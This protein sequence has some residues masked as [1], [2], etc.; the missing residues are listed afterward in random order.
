MKWICQEGTS[1]AVVPAREEATLFN[2]LG[3]ATAKYAQH[4]DKSM[5]IVEHSASRC[6]EC[7]PKSPAVHW[8]G[9]KPENSK[10]AVKR[11]EEV[12]KRQPPTFQIQ[13]LRTSANV[14][15]MKDF[16]VRFVFNSLRLAH[17]AHGQLPKEN[18]AMLVAKASITTMTRTQNSHVNRPALKLKSLAQSLSPLPQ[19]Q[20]DDN[21]D[22]NPFEGTGHKLLNHQKS[23]VA[24]MLKHERNPE[25]FVEREIEEEVVEEIHLRLVGSATRMII[26]RGGV[27]A[28]DIGFGKTVMMLA[29]FK[30]QTE[31]DQHHYELRENKT[32]CRTKALKC[33]M[34]I[35]PRHIVRQWGQ[36]ANK[37]LG[38][39]NGREFVLIEEWSDLQNLKPDD[40]TLLVVSDNIFGEKKYMAALAA[41]VG[42]AVPANGLT[43]KALTEWKGG[44]GYTDWQ[45]SIAKSID[46]RTARKTAVVFEQY[47][48]NRIVWDEVSYENPAVASFVTNCPAVS[49]WLLSGTPPTRD[50]K[51]VCSMATSL[52]LHI[53]RPI[54]LRPGLPRIANGPLLSP[55][56]RLEEFDSYGITKSSEFSLERHR[57]AERF[58]VAFTACNKIDRESHKFQV[59]EQVLVCPPTLAEA[60]TYVRFQA[61]VRIAD[62]DADGLKPAGINRMKQVL[63]YTKE[64]LD[65]EQLAFKALLHAANFP[66]RIQMSFSGRGSTDSETPYHQRVVNEQESLLEEARI[67]VKYVFKKLIWLAPR[68][69]MSIHEGRTAANQQA[70]DKQDYEDITADLSIH[71]DDLNKRRLKL[72]QGRDN[73]A[74]LAKAILPA[75]NN[76]I[77]ACI[78]NKKDLFGLDAIKGAKGSLLPSFSTHD[79]NINLLYKSY[80]SRWDEFY[81][82]AP[83]DAT[84]RF[85][86]TDTGAP[87]NTMK[88]PNDDVVNLLLAFGEYDKAALEVQAQT[89]PGMDNL[90]AALKK[91]IKGSL[92]R[93]DTSLKK[94]KTDYE[95]RHPDEDTKSLNDLK[96]DNL[97]SILRREGLRVDATKSKS[98][99]IDV[100][101]NHKNMSS[102]LGAYA[103]PSLSG[104]HAATGMP[105]LKRTLRIRGATKTQTNDE[106]FTTWSAFMSACRNLYQQL[107]QVRCAKVFRDIESQIAVTCSED[108]CNSTE[109]LELV[110]QCG[111][112]L[113]GAHRED[114]KYC[115]DG[116]NGCVARWDSGVVKLSRFSRVKDRQILDGHLVSSKSNETAKDLSLSSKLIYVI[117]LIRAV[118]ENERVVMFAQHQSI[119]ETAMKALNNEGIK[120]ATTYNNVIGNPVEDFK[121]GKYKVLLMKVNSAEAAGG[122]LVMANHVIFL[123]PVIGNSQHL[124]NSHMNQASG[125]C[126][127][128]GQRAERVH[129]YHCVMEGTIEVEVLELR[130]RQKVQVEPGEALGKLVPQN[131]TGL[132]PVG[133]SL[134]SHEVWK[135]LNEQDLSIAMDFENTRVD[136]SGAYV[137]KDDAENNTE[138]NTNDVATCHTLDQFAD[139]PEDDRAQIRAKYNGLCDKYK[140]P[141][142]KGQVEYDDDGGSESDSD[143]PDDDDESSDGD[144]HMD[145]HPPP[146]GKGHSG[147][148]KHSSK[149]RALDAQITTKAYIDPKAQTTTTT[150]SA[151]NTQP[152]TEPLKKHDGSVNSKGLKRAKTVD[153]EDNDVDQDESPR[154]KRACLRNR[155]DVL[156]YT[157]PDNSSEDLDDEDWDPSNSED[158]ASDEEVHTLVDD[159]RVLGNEVRDLGDTD[160]RPNDSLDEDLYGAPDYDAQKKKA[161]EQKSRDQEHVI[162]DDQEHA[163]EDDQDHAIEEGQEHA[164]EEDQ[165]HADEEDQE[166]AD[167][168]LHASA[169]EIRGLT[170]E[171]RDLRNEIRDLRNEVRD[172]IRNQIRNEVRNAIRGLRVDIRLD[173]H[174]EIRGLAHEIRGSTDGR[175]NDRSDEAFYDAAEYD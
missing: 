65:G 151:P 135:G 78:R 99:V 4:I 107:A 109:A 146:S 30:L 10:N 26:R 37:F 158:N 9:T 84:S 102:G 56:T 79:D 67:Y 68:L 166:H 71:L 97:V 165:E 94:H 54:D 149:P 60:S 85:T 38:F 104:C 95:R 14:N 1:W 17:K 90:R 51:D 144:D 46:W 103:T 7:V 148:G 32:N 164:I 105:F 35:C 111:H 24:W 133:S 143:G 96:K 66:R 175:R 74:E 49:K 47:S 25:P 62:M 34:V 139:L 118:P 161:R 57:Q 6:G 42:H 41:C 116:T 58:L 131:S 93:R 124:Y 126:I 76:D 48:F 155:K 121:K 122:N 115:G 40:H 136:A 170:N 130:Q 89:G 134:S 22:N 3:Y 132:E 87:P 173:M 154:N 5:Q 55:R 156:S 27:I 45:S 75:E 128:Y 160:G 88:L 69:H 63:E 50:L 15:E 159:A 31:F 100:L 91:H 53:A 64:P 61:E 92:K 52:G 162:E 44:R 23:T 153:E 117:N 123:T 59:V 83:E 106:Y 19:A 86:A 12:R 81:L 142:E 21:D 167:E 29:I 150:R 119:L 73:Y 137:Q 101:E 70:K 77:D 20:G 141:K 82:L 113:C 2:T 163:I 168:E 127:R 140:W 8:K 114:K 108:G 169:H 39:R 13:V 145:Q 152:V 157:E 172:D 171:V 18:K 125:R 174:D 112:V 11:Y 129:I 33:N 72:F 16:E 28:D 80:N 138:S 110:I 147:S 120:C 43:A 36:E 98:E